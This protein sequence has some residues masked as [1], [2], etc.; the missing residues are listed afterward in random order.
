MARLEEEHKCPNCGSSLFRKT[1]SGM[2]C[3]NCSTRFMNPYDTRS[4]NINI[5]RDEA[6][7]EK[8]RAGERK[9]KRSMI[10]SVI[11]V[12]FCI[13]IFVGFYLFIDN[14]TAATPP[15]NR[16]SEYVGQNIQ[17]VTQLFKDSGFKN[18]ETISLHDVTSSDD[19]QNQNTVDKI[20]I[21]GEED[22]ETGVIVKNRKTYKKSTPVKIYFHGP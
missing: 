11:T 10:A 7:I 5:I 8:V 22:W 19:S 20:Y 21:G 17:I 3:V 16:A 9:H 2:E 15:A 18:V 12:L 6:K 13:G 14:N 4:T 1:D